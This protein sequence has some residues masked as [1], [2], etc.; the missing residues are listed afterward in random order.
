M[1]GNALFLA[2]HRLS[3]MESELRKIVELSDSVRKKYRSLKKGQVETEQVI[4]KTFKPIVEPLQTLLKEKKK[5]RKISTAEMKDEIK[6]ENM[7]DEETFDEKNEE[8]EAIKTPKFLKLD[9]VIESTP[10]PNIEDEL[11]NLL[12]TPEGVD[13]AKSYLEQYG[14]ISSQYMALYITKDSRIDKGSYG[15]KYEDGEWKLGNSTIR[16]NHD[17]L[18]IGD[19]V[20]EGTEG[21]Y[22]LIFMKD[23]NKLLITNKDEDTYYN[24]LKKAEVVV[25]GKGN[26]SYKY[27]N[28]VRPR[29][30]SGSGIFKRFTE[31]I[32]QYV[33]W[34]DINELVERLKLLIA[35]REAGH[36]GHENEIISI[37]EELKEAKIIV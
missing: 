14:P 12:S 10:E 27:K 5:K 18:F 24:I 31:T 34:D 7:D 30:K 1:I 33:Y 36:S 4:Q 2:E 6:S 26:R 35:S 20:Y 3:S 37:I 11:D 28:I 13:Q 9:P 23:P 19:E 21:L 32:P 22:E 15:V 25:P 29:F 17:D 8:M 16:I